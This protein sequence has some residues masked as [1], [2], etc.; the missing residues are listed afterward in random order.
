LN[1]IP[2]KITPCP[3]TEAVIEMRFEPRKDPNAVYG[4]IYEELSV[5]FPESRPT[6]FADLPREFIE[7]SFKYNAHYELSNDNYLARIGPRTL[8]IHTKG[9]YPGGS[10]FMEIARQT[11]D[12]IFTKNIPKDIVWLSTRYVNGFPKSIAD[13]CDWQIKL[14]T[15]SVQNLEF[16]FRFIDNSDLTNSTIRIATNAILIAATNPANRFT[17]ID[18]DTKYKD[19]SIVKRENL[20][21]LLE[22]I[23]LEEKRIFFNLL[24]EQFIQTLNPEY[25]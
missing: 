11:L 1:R 3:I 18:V 15:K 5:N 24:S 23:H 20:E 16:D 6:Q 7:G 12:I 17:I 2:K 22:Q 4:L 9:E 13:E 10:A 8:S 25:D 19:G 14:N 21:Q